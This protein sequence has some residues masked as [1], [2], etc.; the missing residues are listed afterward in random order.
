M[1]ST[2]VIEERM[3]EISPGDWA[4]VGNLKD[5]GGPLREA[6]T[7]ML[8]VAWSLLDDATEPGTRVAV[9]RAVELLDATVWQLTSFRERLERLRS[10]VELEALIAEGWKDAA[11]NW[12]EKAEQTNPATVEH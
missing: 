9:D 2:Q 4:L 11:G 12:T 3:S 6:V 1:N 8:D 7:G 10:Q 5:R